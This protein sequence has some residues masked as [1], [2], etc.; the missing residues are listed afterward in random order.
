MV[1]TPTGADGLEYVEAAP[2]PFY[3]ATHADD[4]VS[5]VMELYTNDSLWVEVSKRAVAHA[6]KVFSLTRQAFEI[7]DLLQVAF[8]PK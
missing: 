8:R 7:E 5:R 3:I 1:T 2:P 6:H 4:F